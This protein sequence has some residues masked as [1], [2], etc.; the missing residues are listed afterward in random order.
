MTAPA[1]VE[2]RSAF[3]PTIRAFLLDLANTVPPAGGVD[4]RTEEATPTSGWTI[5]NREQSLHTGAEIRPSGCIHGR[6]TTQTHTLSAGRPAAHNSGS[7]CTSASL[8]PLQAADNSLRRT[9]R[10]GPTT[11]RE[12]MS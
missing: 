3:A 9:Y 12:R 1:A 4:R 8:R 2:P 6:G 7:A 11:S 10:Y 5:T